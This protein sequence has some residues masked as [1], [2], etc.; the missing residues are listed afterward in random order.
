MSFQ[1]IVSQRQHCY[2]LPSAPVNA[3]I[4]TMVTLE[5]VTQDEVI[6]WETFLLW[7]F[8]RPDRIGAITIIFRGGYLPGGATAETEF[9]H[10]SQ[11]LPILDQHEELV[12]LTERYLRHVGRQIEKGEDFRHVKTKTEGFHLS[13]LEDSIATAEKWFFVGMYERPYRNFT[14]WVEGVMLRQDLTDVGESL[15]A[16]I[17]ILLDHAVKGAFPGTFLDSV[18]FFVDYTKQTLNIHVQF[19]DIDG[20]LV[21]SHSF[22]CGITPEENI[23]LA[24]SGVVDCTSL[25]TPTTEQLMEIAHE[26]VELKGA[27]RGQ[28]HDLPETEP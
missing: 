6:P 23:L 19:R 24:K 28:V 15:E 14:S 12:D 5:E 21:K 27:V 1:F 7:S 9:A 3:S 8:T 2:L 11:G 25:E 16:R 26:I 17:A 22:Y 4:A 18:R 13:S 10:Y 20:E